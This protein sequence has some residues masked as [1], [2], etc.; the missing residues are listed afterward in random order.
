MVKK[1]LSRGDFKITYT[2]Q[3]II[4]FKDILI[5]EKLHK[6]RYYGIGHIAR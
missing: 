4:G 3:Y 1:A 2:I 6:K 5:N